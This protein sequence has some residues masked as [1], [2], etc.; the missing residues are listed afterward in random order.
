MEAVALEPVLSPRPPKLLVAMQPKLPGAFSVVVGEFCQCS[1]R[2]LPFTGHWNFLVSAELQC[3]VT[4]QETF[5]GEAE[6]TDTK[7]VGLPRRFDPVHLSHAACVMMSTFSL[8]LMSQVNSA[9]MAGRI[10]A[11]M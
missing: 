2:D 5:V 9:R 7:N 8:S 3:D 6:A 4:Q 11:A 10:A 1:A